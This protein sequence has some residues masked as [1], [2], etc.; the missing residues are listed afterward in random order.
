MIRFATGLFFSLL[1]INGLLSSCTK[2]D[3]TKVTNAINNVA[4]SSLTANISSASWSADAASGV[5]KAG[6]I[7]IS[8]AQT[9]GTS[10]QITM[11]ATITPG[12]YAFGVGT[13][14]NL[15][16]SKNQATNYVAGSGS[17]VISSFADSTIAGTFS[18][19]MANP[20]VSTD[21][22]SVTSGK[23]SVKL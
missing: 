3:T 14:Y 12:S 21:T 7:L 17:L 8:G 1:L 19:S 22:L 23:F 2:V 16:Y 10:L 5:S 11:P 20:L 6:V 18:G 15:A 9:N 4:S 13:A